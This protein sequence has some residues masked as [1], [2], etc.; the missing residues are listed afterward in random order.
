MGEMYP[1][2]ARAPLSCLQAGAGRGGVRLLMLPALR[3]ESRS[4]GALG[5]RCGT[6][7][8]DTTKTPLQLVRERPYTPEVE[9]PRASAPKEQT[10]PGKLSGKCTAQL[11]NSGEGRQTPTEGAKFAPATKRDG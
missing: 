2:D 11:G 4:S 9:G 10:L 1:E 7:R 3:R 5:V 6:I 8:G